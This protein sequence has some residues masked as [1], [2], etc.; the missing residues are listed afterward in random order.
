KTKKEIPVKSHEEVQTL[1]RMDEK[2]VSGRIISQW[3]KPWTYECGSCA[4]ALPPRRGS[5]EGRRH[6]RSCTVCAA[7]AAASRRLLAG[8]ARDERGD[9]RR[10]HY[11][12]PFH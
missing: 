4:H 10:I 5:R 8:P 6:D 2:Q 1:S 7:C 12:P 11:F 9:E 3:T